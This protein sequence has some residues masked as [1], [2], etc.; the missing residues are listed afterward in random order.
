M[1]VVT[2]LPIDGREPPSDLSDHD[3]LA[4]RVAVSAPWHPAV[5]ARLEALPRTEPL[6]DPEPSAEGVQ[7]V[8]PKGAFGRLDEG[9]RLNA[10]AVGL[11]VIEGSMD[12][13]SLASEILRRVDPEASSL[14]EEPDDLALDFLALGTAKW[15][16]RDLTVAM[17]HADC[18]D[19]DSLTRE[20]LTGAKAWAEGDSAGAKNRLRAAFELLTQA[21]ERFYPTDAY[22][23]DFYLLDSGSAPGSLNEALEARVPISVMATGR[24]VEAFAKAD[25]EAMKALA[26]AVDEGWADVIGGPYTEADEPLLPVESVLWQYRHAAEIYRR[27]LSDRS[28]ETYARRRFGLYPMLPQV[29]RRFAIRFGLHLALDDGRF[30]LAPKAKRLWEAPDGT[31]LEV[32]TRIPGPADRASEG[33]RLVWR[34]ARSMKQ[35]H[36]AMVPLV[37]WPDR[38]SGW[39]RDLRRVASYSPV[40]G[41]FV[42]AGDYFHL[43]DRPWDTIRNSL[44]GYVSPYL[45]QNVERGNSTPVSSRVELSRQRARFEAAKGLDA[46][47]RSMVPSAPDQDWEALEERVETD[48]VEREELETSLSR[49]ARR[50][51]EVVMTGAGD[52]P[53]FL[54]LNPLGTSRRVPVLLPDAAPDLPPEGPL[55]AAQFTDEGVWAVVDLPAFGFA[56]VPRQKATETETDTPMERPRTIRS[57]EGRMLRNEFLEFEIDPETGGLRSV[58]GPD[59]PTPRL[60]LQIVANGLK[61]PDGQPAVSSMQADSVEVEYAGPALGQAVS[62]GRLVGPKGRTLARFRL[63]MRLLSGSPTLRI[64]LSLEDV[65]RAFQIGLEKGS[66]WSDNLAVRWAWADSQAKL[67][68][69][70]LLGAEATSAE[71]PETP[72]AFEILTRSQKTTLLFGGLAHHRRFGPRMLDTVL[73]AGKE[74]AREFSLGVVLDLEHAHSAALDLVSPSPVV[75]AQGPP[76]TGPSGWFFHLDHPNVAVTRVDYSEESADSRGACLVFHLL[77]TA[78]RPSRCKLRLYRDPMW[79]RQTDFLGDLI[80]DLSAEADA[81]LVD[82]TPRELARVEVFFS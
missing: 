42:M 54:V 76:R 41:R 59:E 4:A 5:L 63:R 53:G 58:R 46:V 32:L 70:S 73:L 49:A 1:R 78:G 12:R 65:D 7:K 81:V 68:R 64:D 50:L 25:P 11:P 75:A 37:H 26:E 22:V 9:H 14:P 16:L 28:V 2:L 80:V 55:R 21:R 17:G 52:R 10:E 45:D 38:V 24:A 66:P 69:T 31:A 29:A 39:Y 57:A 27:H 6:D 67:R 44:D 47:Y 56:W 74:T 71:R 34:L 36:A 20:V 77:E 19:L 40:F 61:T 30:P 60:A 8:V 3:A 18:L 23:L 13:I 62:R 51:S 48:G 43:T 72:D 33:P 35:D 82:L 79:A 15:M